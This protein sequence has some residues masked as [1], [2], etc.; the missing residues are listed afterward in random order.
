MYKRQAIVRVSPLPEH[1]EFHA[2]FFPSFAAGLTAVR[3]IVQNRWPLSLLRFSTPTETQTTLALA[4]HERVIGLLETMLSVRGVGGE[5][6]MLLC[7]FTGRAATI[8]ETRR[9]WQMRYQA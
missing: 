1:E 8:R 3:Q 6:C 5:K 2:V 4:G 9:H 7:G